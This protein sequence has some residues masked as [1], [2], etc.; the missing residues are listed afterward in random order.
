MAEAEGEKVVRGEVQLPGGV[1]AR[2][3]AGACPWPWQQSCGAG[4]VGGP[5]HDGEEGGEGG[6]DGGGAGGR[7]EEAWWGPV[8]QAPGSG[9]PSPS[10]PG[11]V[12]S[13]WLLPPSPEGPGR[14]RGAGRCWCL[15]P[16]RRRSR[17]RSCLPRSSHPGFTYLKQLES[18][19]RRRE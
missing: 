13:G 5:P 11:T 15:G 19:S 8:V 10:P 6:E 3:R 17:S 12:G 14:R 1:P 16:W 4:A 2:P 7:V 18:C 9:C